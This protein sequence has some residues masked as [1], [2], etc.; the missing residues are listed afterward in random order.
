M[1]LLMSTFGF[2]N[3]RN[4]GGLSAIAQLNWGIGCQVEITNELKLCVWIV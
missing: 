2:Q 4:P 3:P 1:S